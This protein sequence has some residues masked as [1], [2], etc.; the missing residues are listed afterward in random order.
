MKPVF[1]SQIAYAL[2]EQTF[3]LEQ[4]FAA[5]RI[6]SGAQQFREAGFSEH[7]V[8]AP[9]TSPYE[10]TRQAVSQIESSLPGTGAIIYATCLPLNGNI[11]DP[12]KYTETRDVKH[13]MDFPA[14]HLQ[15]DFGLDNASVIGLNQQACTS[16][17][18]S[19]RL[20]RALIQTEPDVR[21][22]LCVTSDRFPE[23][24]IY[25]QAYNVISD[26]AAACVVS[27][28]PQ[29]YRLI[30]THAITN[31]ALAQA[32]D[33]ETVGSYFNYTYRLMEETLAKASLKMSDIQWVIPQN[34]NVNAWKILARLLGIEFERVFFGSISEVAHIISSDNIVNLKKLETTGNLKSGDRLLL[35]MAG[36]G[37]NW[38]A[39]ILEKV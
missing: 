4:S 27:D 33:D 7:R 2:G 22:V 34:T 25:E 30:C 28:E 14:S 37:L 9:G 1:V 32:S 3:T 15:A 18:G 21:K 26:G 39:V 13:L 35:F 24:A 11:G 31:G 20:A 8:C 29:G 23:G 36:F 19:M 10:L 16:M 5:K 38:Q 12:A 6:F 17:L